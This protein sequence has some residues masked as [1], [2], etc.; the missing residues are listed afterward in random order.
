MH[1]IIVIRYGLLTAMLF[2]S[3]LF[4]QDENYDAVYLSLTKEYILN[5]DGSIDYHFIKEQR[6]QTYRSFNS[7]YGETFVVYCPEY[8]KIKINQAYTIMS[9]GKRIETPENAFNEVLPGFAANAPFYNYL[10]E[11]VI[12]HT[13]LERGA[14]INLD[15]QIH[16][17]QGFYPALMGN[18]LLCESEPVKQLIIRV[19]IPSGT[20]LFFE[21][22]NSECNPEITKENNFKIYTW[23]LKNIAAISTEEWQ[24]GSYEFYPRLIFGTSDNRQKI[25]GFLTAQNAFQYMHTEKMKKGIDDIISDNKGDL[26]IVLRL[27]E[28]IVNNIRLISIP[29]RYTGYKCRTAEMAWNSNYGT[30][31]EKTILLVTLLK[32]AGITAEP[33][34]VVRSFMNKE[35]IG[36]LADIED[37]VVRADLK[38]QGKIYLSITNLNAQNLSLSLPGRT[39]MS[40]DTTI[41]MKTY[42]TKD[43]SFKSTVK[44]T[45]ICSSD[46]KIT[47]EL[48]IIQKDAINPFFGLFRDKNKIKSFIT[49]GI[50][51]G[52][53]KDSKKFNSSEHETSQ[54]FTVLAE[55]PFRRD[56]FLFY[57]SIPYL[58]SGIDA[59]NMKSLSSKRETPLE[60][61]NIAEEIYEYNFTLP[62]G[63]IVF[64]PETHIHITNHVGS[65]IFDIEPKGGTLNIT[66]KI[67]FYKRIIPVSMYFD[68]KTLM[69][70]W[71]NPR[72]RELIFKTKK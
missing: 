55:K 43:P 63:I 57:F 45:F 59:W 61:P 10:R 54:T 2:A 48:T 40:I 67:L 18:E 33:V 7:L 27:Q 37:F 72:Y 49:G 4:A 29:L 35:K 36:T 60:I 15:Y 30:P 28:R 16:S 47:G 66:K 58:N 8:Q 50:S 22:I 46:P 9:S 5:T 71:N 17:Q 25:L 52:D 23:S 38:E 11:L 14:S 53:I 32:I 65:F 56:T 21:T 31:L 34:A 70:N 41:Q 24:Q 12:T 1:K 3:R 51:G 19:K 20:N 62:D 6:L 13:G 42:T 26:D 64:S 39:L 69:D 68:F 44:G